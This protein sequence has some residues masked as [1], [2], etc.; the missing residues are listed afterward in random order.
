MKRLKLPLTI[1]LIYCLFCFAQCKK[2]NT[3]SNGL[4][5]A[6]QNRINTSFPMN[7]RLI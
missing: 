5:A 1:A 4:P 2:S 6:T 7:K 3:D